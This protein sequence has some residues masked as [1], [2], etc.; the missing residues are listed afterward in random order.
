MTDSSVNGT[1]TSITNTHVPEETEATVK[2]VWDD[3]DDQDGIR[4]EEL[5]VT[6]SNGTSVTLNEDNNW[7]AKVENLP[8]YENHGEE[9]EYTWT[10][11]E[12]P[13]G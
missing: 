10:E 13:E 5:E 4:P 1:I 11:G 12:L 6:L 2:K 3:N 9:I 7:T 8:K